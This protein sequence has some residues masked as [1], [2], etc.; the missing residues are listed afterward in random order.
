VERPL[1]LYHYHE[2]EKLYHDNNSTLWLI[3]PVKTL[4]LVGTGGF[5]FLD[6]LLHPQH[7]GN[8]FLAVRDPFFRH[9]HPL[10]DDSV[11]NLIYGGV[12]EYQ[13]I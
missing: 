6:L 12:W 3:P 13:I 2:E 7:S 9:G 5:S 10:F 11:I 4:L 8:V 1:N